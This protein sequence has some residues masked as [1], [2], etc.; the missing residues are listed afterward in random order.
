MAPHTTPTPAPR[1][2]G[3]WSARPAAAVA[4]ADGRMGHRDNNAPRVATS[5]GKGG[6][7]PPERV[8]CCI[9]CMQSEYDRDTR[10]VTQQL[11]ADREEAEKDYQCDVVGNLVMNC[12]WSIWFIDPT[13]GGWPPSS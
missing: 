13:N 12:Y 9:V 2:G 7:Q 1:G 5:V 10:G 11:L 6:V 4:V 8:D 3:A